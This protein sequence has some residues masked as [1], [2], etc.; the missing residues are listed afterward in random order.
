M[1]P[2][3]RDAVE[4][5][6]IDVAMHR[7]VDGSYGR[8]ANCDRKIPLARLLAEPTAT[9]CSECQERFEQTHATEKTPVL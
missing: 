2:I 4:L 3:D 1:T 7:L 9:R 6:R 5:R 8:C